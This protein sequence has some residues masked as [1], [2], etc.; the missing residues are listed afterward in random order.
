[1]DTRTG[2]DHRHHIDQ[3]RAD[4]AAALAIVNDVSIAEADAIRAALR[5]AIDH[6]NAIVYGYETALSSADAFDRQCAL[7]ALFALIPELQTVAA[8]AQAAIA[9][10]LP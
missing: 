10:L 5:D 2:L 6:A 4:L 7:S 8:T 1:M 9:A 3:A